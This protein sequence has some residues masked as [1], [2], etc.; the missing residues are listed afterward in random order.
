MFLNLELPRAQR[1]SIA[2][3]SW[4]VWAMAS[5]LGSMSFPQ[6]VGSAEGVVAEALGKSMSHICVGVQ[7][8]LY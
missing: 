7:T 6:C 2:T 5:C 3:V 1:I 8:K 4:K